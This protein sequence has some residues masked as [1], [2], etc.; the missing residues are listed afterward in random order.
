M[1]LLGA[2]ITRYPKNSSQ[3]GSNNKS[4]KNIINI[5]LDF[6]NPLNPNMPSLSKNIICRYKLGRP[7]LQRDYA[8]YKVL[9]DAYSLPLMHTYVIFYI[10]KKTKQF[11]CHYSLNAEAIFHDYHLLIFKNAVFYATNSSIFNILI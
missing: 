7:I 4:T 5:S 3:N 10:N 8:S 2:K 6:I 9:C 11:F 1:Q